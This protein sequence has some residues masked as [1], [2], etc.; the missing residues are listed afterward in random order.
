MGRFRRSLSSLACVLGVMATGCDAP[1]PSFDD[2]VMFRGDAQHSGVFDTQ[3]VD[4]AAGLLWRFVTDGP[5]RSSPVVSAETLYVGSTDGKFYALDRMTGQE[6]WHV[7]VG[8][9]VSSSAAIAEGLAIFVSRDGVSRAVDAQTGELRWRFDT[10]PEMDW[11]WGMEGWDVYLS[12]PVVHEGRVVFGA[13]DGVVY[14]LELGT[15]RELW[16]FATQGRI[17]STPAIA[18]GVVFVGSADGIVY[19]LSLED[20]AERW[21]YETEGVSFDSGEFGFD[22]RSIIAS[23]AVVDGTVYVGSRDGYMYA[24]E[25]ATGVRKWR[26][27]HQVS[28]AMSSPSV[29]GE[30]LFSGTSDG[31]FVHRVDVGTGEEVWRFVAE[32]FTWSSPALV[33]STVYIGDDGGNLHAVDAESGVVRWS[34]KAGGGVD[35]SPWVADGVVYFGADDGAVYAVGGDARPIHRAVFWDEEVANRTGFPHLETRVHF[36]QHGYDVLDA[37]ALISF[38]QVRAEDGA[39]SV[40]VF[41]VDRMP[42]AL[43]EDPLETG[44]LRQY[45]ESAGKVL[46]LGMPPAFLGTNDAGQVIVDRGQTQELLDV[47]FSAS[48]FDFY[49]SMP[50]DLGRTWGLN[51]GWV[52]SYSVR[53]QEGIDVLAIDEN[54]RAGAWVKRYG[55]PIGSGFVAMGLREVTPDDLDAAQAL[56]EFGLGSGSR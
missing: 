41:A 26:I 3:G 22:R 47:D 11:A 34:F 28:W 40:V 45:L 23:P 24:L 13:G 56:A 50:T 9:P 17:R 37:E 8:S 12:S 1:A 33:G 52:S 19:A 25:Q 10:G 2:P 35:S 48:D 42:P 18:D 39:S 53:V 55:G 51:R 49:G 43:A 44:L 15:G 27:S 54:G 36:E 32:G 7:D 5:V 30:A 20:G 21:R 16:R 6:R 14:A 4:Q 31:D 38:L 46:W 29:L